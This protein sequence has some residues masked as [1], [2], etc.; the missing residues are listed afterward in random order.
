MGT[1]LEYTITTFKSLCRIQTILKIAPPIKANLIIIKDTLLQLINLFKRK[2]PY[3]PSFNKIPAKIIEP[4]TGAS[5]CA[6]GNH[7]WKKKIG[8]FT[9][10]AR[11]LIN[12]RN[13]EVST[14]KIILILIV[15]LP[16]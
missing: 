4:E 11:I 2:R 1:T 8:N 3:P 6:L 16:C 7:K 13:L 15:S 14:L 9:K 10:N 5:T 12:Q